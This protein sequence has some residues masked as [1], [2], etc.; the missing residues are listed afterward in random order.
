M[1]CGI[2]FAHLREAAPS[3]EGGIPNILICGIGPHRARESLLKVIDQ[4]DEVWNLGLAGAKR[5]EIGEICSIGSV[6]SDEGRIELGEGK[7]LYTSPRPIW[8]RPFEGDLVDMEG[9]AIAKVCQEEGVP[10]KL[11]K[12]ISD[13]AQ[14]E[15]RPLLRERLDEL[16]LKLYDFLRHASAPTSSGTEDN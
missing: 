2:V 5:G 16:A 7:E 15:G 14:A 4:Y 6:F 3:I 8:G 1:A 13:H 11:W 9:Y 10:C 12:I